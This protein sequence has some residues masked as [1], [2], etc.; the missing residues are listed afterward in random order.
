MKNRKDNY[1]KLKFIILNKTKQKII[2]ILTRY[3]TNDIVPL[4]WM[5][6]LSF[7]LVNRFLFA[8]SD[9]FWNS[10]ADQISLIIWF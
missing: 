2:I 7:V 9:L 3:D 10:S 8:D 5:F 6:I 1:K 4:E